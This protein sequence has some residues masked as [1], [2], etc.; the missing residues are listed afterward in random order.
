MNLFFR[1]LII[2]FSARQQDAV[3][4]VNKRSD[5]FRV[6]LH[7]LG[8]R[9]HLPNYRVFS[10]MELGR[11]GIWHSSRLALSGRY[12]L[13]MIAAQDFIY[14]KPI[15]PFQAFTMTTE[16]LSWDDKYFYYQHQFLCGDKLVAIGLVKEIALKSGKAVAPNALLAADSALNG[17]VVHH[18]GDEHLHPV[19]EKWLALQQAIKEHS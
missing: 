5:R 4:L 17:S 15:R 9:D 11:F 1:M 8:W 2:I 13:R 16:I 7:D 12:G 10:F 19:V 3:A 18:G 14:L 6:W